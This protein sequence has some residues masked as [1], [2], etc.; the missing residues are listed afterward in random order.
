MS[1]SP[2]PTRQLL[3]TGSKTPPSDVE[4]VSRIHI[5]SL[6]PT[7]SGNERYL[8]HSPELM[9]SNDIALAVRKEFP[10]LRDRVPSPEEGSGSG[11]SE[12]LVKMDTSRFDG[13]FGK[14]VWKS[15]RVS[16]L[17]TVGDFVVDFEREKR[18]GR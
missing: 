5:E 7:I 9:A 17:E 2:Q 3:L 4:D 13:V 14:R 11:L 6:S 15:A 10:Q 1:P 8:F 16:A 18:K 12:K